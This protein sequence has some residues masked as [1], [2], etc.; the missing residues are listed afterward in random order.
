MKWLSIKTLVFLPFSFLPIQSIIYLDIMEVSQ[1]CGTTFVVRDLCWIIIVVLTILFI[2]LFI[3]LII[4]FF[5]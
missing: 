5:L 2:Y 3:Y 1:F 4:F